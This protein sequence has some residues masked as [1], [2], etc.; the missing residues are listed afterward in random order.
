M[1]SWKRFHQA[2]KQRNAA[3]AQ[4][5]SKEYIQSWDKEFIQAGEQLAHFRKIYIDDLIVQAQAWIDLFLGKLPCS[6][7]YFTG[8]E[9]DQPLS[10]V[11]YRN[12]DKDIKYGYST[13]GPHRFDLLI[14]SNSLH[15]SEVFSRG[16][17]K[18][19]ICALYLAQG[20]LFKQQTGQACIYLLDDIL[21]EL[22][23]Y[24]QTK[25]LEVLA[26]LNAQVF[27][28]SLDEQSIKPL[29]SIPS[30]KRFHIIDGR[31]LY[32]P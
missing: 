23:N 21:S 11:L 9:T 7:S 8:W 19:L 12:L 22:D 29:F 10:S 6:L 16:E 5:Y 28:T 18:R 17:Q 15:V 30:H 13:V 24:Y 3:L 4:R 31:I 1:E 32:S 25:V 26:A 14:Q 20:Q 27:V 2:L